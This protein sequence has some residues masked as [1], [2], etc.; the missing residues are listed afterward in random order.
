METGG[1]EIMLGGEKCA[2][3]GQRLERTSYRLFF[4]SYFSY[5]DHECLAHLAVAGGLKIYQP[6]HRTRKVDK[7]LENFIL[8]RYLSSIGS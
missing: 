4:L 5:G 3:A 7:T 6:S 1:E 2:T 8:H